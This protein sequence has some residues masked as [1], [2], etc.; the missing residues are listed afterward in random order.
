MTATLPPD[1]LRDLRDNVLRYVYDHGAGNPFFA[2]DG[3]SVAKDLDIAPHEMNA[4]AMLLHSQGLFESRGPVGSISLN[5]RGQAEAERLGPA[6][7]FREPIEPNPVV[8]NANYSV[9][10]VAGHNSHQSATYNLDQSKL[11]ALLDQI[12][13]EI[14]K[15][16]LTSAEKEEAK[17]L[18]EA[19]KQGA[20]SRLGAAGMRAIG[21]SLSSLLT[22][23]GSELGKRLVA[24]LGIG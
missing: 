21:G 9:V 12:E 13:A 14:P 6:V 18:V 24:L 11:I 22:S 20:A 10:Q 2:T 17:G 5:D 16:N 23:A 3:K 8:I 7:R 1:R 4:V 19:G 15:L